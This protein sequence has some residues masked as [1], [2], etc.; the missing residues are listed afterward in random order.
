MRF[1]ALCP[2]ETLNQER[3]KHSGTPIHKIIR[4]S[5]FNTVF[6][7]NLY[8]NNVRTGTYFNTFLPKHGGNQFLKCFVH[9]S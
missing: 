7:N 8:I 4:V 2:A 3:A 6:T 9:F 1:V 5:Y